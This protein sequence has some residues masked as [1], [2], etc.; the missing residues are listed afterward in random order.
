MSTITLNKDSVQVGPTRYYFKDYDAV[1]L[2]RV[3][4]SNIPVGILICGA[5]A[6]ICYFGYDFFSS[7][8]SPRYG[9][10]VFSV[11]L[12]LFVMYLGAQ[13]ID[14]DETKPIFVLNLRNA[15]GSVEIGRYLDQ[16]EANKIYGQLKKRWPDNEDE[17]N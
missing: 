13:K 3:T 1:E 7:A 11:L 5:G 16:G 2:K 4:E 9:A 8:V 17:L 14:G 12:G 6:L 15:I 10:M